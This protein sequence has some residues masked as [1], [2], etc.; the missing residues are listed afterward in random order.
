MSPEAGAALPLRDYASL[1]FCVCFET[2]SDYVALAVLELTMQNSFAWNPPAST[3]AMLRVKA[4]VTVPSSVC[5]F[6][7]RLVAPVL[8]L[9]RP[10]RPH[11]ELRVSLGI[12]LGTSIL[13]F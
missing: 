5:L 1:P 12:L 9:E 4:R 13:P 10:G 2:G 6:D 3:S 8:G 11:K 7:K